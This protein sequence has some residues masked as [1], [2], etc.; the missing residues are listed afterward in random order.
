MR[1]HTRLFSFVGLISVGLMLLSCQNVPSGYI[2]NSK[3]EIAIS[4]AS[5]LPTQRNY[6]LRAPDDDL[7]YSYQNIKSSSLIAKRATQPFPLMSMTDDGKN[8][9]EGEHVKWQFS[10]QIASVNNRDNLT[11]SLSSLKNKAPNL[12]QGRFITNVETAMVQNTHVYRLKFG[13]YKYY[14]NAL[15]DC[16]TFKS[17]NVDCL[18]SNYTDTPYT[19]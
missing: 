5:K 1:Y 6:V 17:F 9:S 16:Q 10:L 18:V 3:T 14:K 12:F 4:E 2:D 8:V 13:A 19:Q 11:T 15:A 7:F